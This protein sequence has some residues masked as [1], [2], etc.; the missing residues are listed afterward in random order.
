M[1]NLKSAQAK[2]EQLRRSLPEEP[3]LAN[4]NYIIG[5]LQAIT[6]QFKKV[7]SRT[8]AYSQGQ[9]AKFSPK[10]LKQLE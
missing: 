9:I 10:K 1:I 7:Q 3:A 8:T 6:H 4:R 2:T 5:Q